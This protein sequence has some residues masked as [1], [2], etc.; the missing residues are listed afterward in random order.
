MYQILSI[1][2]SYHTTGSSSANQ[3][4]T[5]DEINGLNV[6]VY[7]IHYCIYTYIYYIYTINTHTHILQLTACQSICLK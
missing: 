2:Q 7:N 6:F 5:H 4:M 1:L 3:T